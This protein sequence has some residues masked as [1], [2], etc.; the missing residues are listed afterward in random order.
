[1]PGG[2]NRYLVAGGLALAAFLFFST[3]WFAGL[4]LVALL[5]LAV[6]AAIP[7][8]GA[9]LLHRIGWVRL[10]FVGKFTGLAATAVLVVAAFAVS[11]LA[12]VFAP[13]PSASPNSARGPDSPSTSRPSTQ[14][15]P[16]A[17]NAPT[18]TA[19]SPTTGTAAPLA[20]G[21]AP[22][23]APSAGPTATP[24]PTTAPSSAAATAP[25]T[26]APTVAPTPVPTVAP[27]TVPTI[28]PTPVPS[29]APPATAAPSS[30]LVITRVFYDG[31]VVRTE[32]DEFVEIRN[33]G[34]A[35]QSMSGW[36]LVSARAGQTFIFSAMT[37]TAGQTC[38]VYTNEIH[39]EWCSLSFRSG[40]AIWNNAG[41]RANLT[42]AQGRLVSSMGY[43][44]F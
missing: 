21:L 2:R 9:K 22:L 35:P 42:D 6:A 5:G 31:V 33:T 16:S 40:S 36:R 29:T 4:V 17:T 1:M 25:P 19:T 28:A 8:V 20:A 24:T 41:D 26:A 37:M 38:R 14:V 15:T 23:S 3:S 30:N 44:G 7:R 27:T 18:V 34:G 11:G 10:P 12:V 32:S 43:N 13:V 39:A